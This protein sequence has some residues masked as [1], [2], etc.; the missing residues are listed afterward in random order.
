MISFK[1]NIGLRCRSIA[2]GTRFIG[3]AD[4]RNRN[5]KVD[6]A[7]ALKQDFL[8][9][10]FECFVIAFAEMLGAKNAI[11][12]EQIFRRPILIRERI[13]NLIIIIGDDG[14]A[15]AELLYSTV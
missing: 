1:A 3:F 11:F 12:I 9:E 2:N 15:D 13:P 14:I 10:S 5:W 8:Q 4:W 7:I 6:R